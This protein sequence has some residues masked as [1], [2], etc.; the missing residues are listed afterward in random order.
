MTLNEALD[1]LWGDV[2]AFYNKESCLIVVVHYPIVVIEPQKYG[3][4]DNYL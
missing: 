3:G 1:S 2:L 4:R